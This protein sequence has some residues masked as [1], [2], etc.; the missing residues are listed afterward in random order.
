ML[1]CRTIPLIGE[2]LLGML[3]MELEDQMLSLM[4]EMEMNILLEVEPIIFRVRS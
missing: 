3:E 4:Q 1:R 2:A